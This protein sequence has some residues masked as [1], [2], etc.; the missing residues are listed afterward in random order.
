M[1]CL[2]EV[3]NREAETLV[4]EFSV[5]DS[6][7]SRSV[8]Y[9]AFSP[10]TPKACRGGVSYNTR[11]GDQNISLTFLKLITFASNLDLTRIFFL[12][13]PIRRAFGKLLF[14]CCQLQKVGLI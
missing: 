14:E 4:M 13:T 12:T 2:T 1:F 9:M 10:R 8:I 3:I 5:N 6:H 7:N 11:T